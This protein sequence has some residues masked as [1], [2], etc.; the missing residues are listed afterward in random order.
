MTA[1]TNT[2]SIKKTRN[3]KQ[4]QAHIFF[5]ISLVLIIWWVPRCLDLS[6]QVL[7]T[8][9]QPWWQGGRGLQPKNHTHAN[10]PTS[11]RDIPHLQPPPRVRWC[12]GSLL[13]LSNTVP[14][15]KELNCLSPSCQPRWPTGPRTNPATEI[16]QPFLSAVK[17]CCCLALLWTLPCKGWL[18]A[19]GEKRQN[20]QAVW[21]WMWKNLSSRL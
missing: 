17:V 1:G 15:G 18:S 6:L 20:K 11:L 9:Q 7:S 3:K 2:I 14:P 5:E 4:K 21:K 12:L 8:I 13:M 16:K 10:T 19:G